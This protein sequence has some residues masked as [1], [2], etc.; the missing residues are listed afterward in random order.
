MA[1]A[2]VCC[3]CMLA[4]AA[5]L[6]SDYRRGENFSRVEILQNNCGSVVEAVQAVSLFSTGDMERD[7]SGGKVFRQAWTSSV[8]NFRVVASGDLGRDCL[9]VRIPGSWWYPEKKLPITSVTRLDD[10]HHAGPAKLSCYELDCSKLNTSLL[11]SPGKCLN[12]KGDWVFLQS[13]LMTH[14]ALLGF[15][16]FSVNVIKT[17]LNRLRASE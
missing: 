3:L 17:S 12:W 13:V 5:N 6:I 1:E 15:S 10:C 7:R 8:V 9:S 14:T 4:V 11:T 2:G 16:L